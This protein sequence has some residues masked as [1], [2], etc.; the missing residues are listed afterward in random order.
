MQKIWSYF[1]DALK[2][3]LKINLKA[4]VIFLDPPYS[5]HVIEEIII[6]ILENDLLKP[7]GI[8]VSEF[9][10]DNLKDKYLN[11]KKI[12]ERTYG[13]KTVYIYK[14]ESIWR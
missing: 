3:I 8:I 11:L 14:M 13:L 12:K 6:F 9:Q 7:K 1:G 5:L 2:N 4:D 10:G